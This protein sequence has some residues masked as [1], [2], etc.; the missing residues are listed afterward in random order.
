M[1][2]SP[3]TPTLHVIG[4]VTEDIAFRVPALPRPGE[5]LIADA[6]TA[7]LGGKGLNQAV[8]AARS[9]VAVRLLA[10]VGED[11]VAASAAALAKA[12]GIAATLPALAPASDQSVIWVAT[13]GENVIVSSAAAAGALDAAAVD[14]FLEAA[15]PGDSLLLQGNLTRAATAAALSRARASGL[16]TIANPSPI[17]WDWTGLWAKVDLAVVNR[18]ELATLTG[19][20]GLEDGIAALHRAGARTVLL[21]MGAEGALLDGP[22][23]RLVQPAA[24]ADV[25]DTAG[26]GDTLCGVYVA[27]R[28][29]GDAP[30]AALAWAARAAAVTIARPG[31]HGAFPDRAALARTP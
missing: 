22:N 8:I 16:A 26:A 18:L 9:G 7:D 11:E 12:E 4:N 27:R 15:A 2:R 28:M 31:T 5:T 21:T 23:G 25:I 1:P 13:S 14:A 29:L 10:P 6:R 30:G 3:D 19:A 20:D 17:R 24:P